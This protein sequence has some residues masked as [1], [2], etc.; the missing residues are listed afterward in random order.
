MD[1]LID[2]FFSAI[3]LVISLDREMVDIVAVSL[4][5]SCYS[6]FS[7]SLLGI[8]IGFVVA[9]E[10]FRGKPR[11]LGLLLCPAGTDVVRL[12]PPLIVTEDEIDRCLELLGQAL[13]RLGAGGSEK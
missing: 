1:L 5:V 2:S 8:P 11:D 4:K 10:S 3:A 12:V 9:F 13:D 6:T 7:A